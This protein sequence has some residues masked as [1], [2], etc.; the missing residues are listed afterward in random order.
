MKGPCVI[1]FP[2]ESNSTQ[3]FFIFYFNVLMSKFRSSKVFESSAKKDILDARPDSLTNR[4]CQTARAETSSLCIAV[5]GFKYKER[6]S[7][8]FSVLFSVAR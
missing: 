3:Q 5:H 6:Y 8:H 7:V 4:L 1:F 2:A